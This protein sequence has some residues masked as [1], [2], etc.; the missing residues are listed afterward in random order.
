MEN[1]CTAH[2]AA[3]AFM[4]RDIMALNSI[5]SIFPLAGLIKRIV[6]LKMCH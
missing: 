6:Y 2:P 3:I 1:L 5:L 4:V